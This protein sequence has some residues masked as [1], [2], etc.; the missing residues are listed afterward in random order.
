MPD[1]SNIEVDNN[2]IV[3][4]NNLVGSN[5]TVLSQAGQEEVKSIL[6][7]ELQASTK[8]LKEEVKKE[9]QEVKKD[10]LTFFGLFASFVTFLS[11]EVQVFKN[12]DNIFEL[13]GICSISLSFVMFFALVINDISKDKSEWADFCKPTYI[14]NLLFVGVGV[15]LLYTGGGKSSSQKFENF[16]KRMKID[17]LQ[18]DSLKYQIIKL[19]I[20]IEEI[21]SVR[22]IN[23]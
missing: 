6:R 19:N 17:S 11:I 1:N 5:N 16:E 18:V 21:D 4:D 10:F 14:I 8:T 12:K 2:N 9:S 15:L 22:K 3:I 20:K 23:R 13:I 7:S